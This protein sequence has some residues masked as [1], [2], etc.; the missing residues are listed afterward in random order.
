MAEAIVEDHAGNKEKLVRKKTPHDQKIVY[1]QASHDHG[2]DGTT[3]SH[4]FSLLVPTIT[5][6]T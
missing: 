3:F 6:Y 4:I 1:T 2:R 5:E